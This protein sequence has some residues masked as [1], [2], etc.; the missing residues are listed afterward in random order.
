VDL[1]V[2]VCK[3]K[4]SL[5]GDLSRPV[6]RQRAVELGCWGELKATAAGVINAL[7]HI[8]A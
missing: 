1:D 8:K 6:V 3:V 7:P 4:L 2:V 5:L